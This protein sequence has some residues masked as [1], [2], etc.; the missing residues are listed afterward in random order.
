MRRR[1]AFRV[2]GSLQVI[3]SGRVVELRSAKQRVLLAALLMKANAP[4]S[5]YELMEHL[6]GDEPSGAARATLQ[7]YVMRLRQS[8]DDLADRKLVRTWPTGYSIHVEDDQLDLLTFQKLRAEARRAPDLETEARLLGEAAALWRGPALDQV[9][10]LRME[11]TDVQRLN[12]QRW[13]VLERRNDAELQLGRHDQLV[14]ELRSLVAEHPLRERFWYQLMLALHRSG[15]QAQALDVFRRASEVLADELGID[16]NAELRALHMEVL[17]GSSAPVAVQAGPSWL[18][19]AVGDFSGRADEVARLTTGLRAGGT[20]TITG[21]GGVGKTSLAVHCAHAV[22]DAFPDGQLYLNLRGGE[23]QP[24]GPAAAL[25]RLLRGLGVSGGAIPSS[26]ED[27]VDL[28]RDLLSDRRILVVLDN[29]VNEAQVRPLLP[30]TTS[31]AALVTSR[32]ALAGLEAAHV[33][34]LDVLPQDDALTLLRTAVG[35]ARCAAEP[36]AA[37][38]IVAYCGQLPLAL[39]VAAARLVARPH[40]QLAKLAGRL[41]DERRRFD[42]LSLGDLDVRASLALSYDGLDASHQTAFRLLSLV[43]TPDFPAWTAS[44]LLGLDVDDAEDHVEALVDARLVDYAGRDAAGQVR[45]RLHDLLRAFG[46]EAATEDPAEALKALFEQW[47][48]LA[49]RADAELPHQAIRLEPAELAPFDLGDAATWFD[50]EWQNI[51]ALV[52]QAAALGLGAQAAEL[53]I[54]SAAFCDLRAR[55]DD[56][57]QLNC[58]GLSCAPPE[59]K[60]VLFQQRGILRARMHDYV[61]A[62]ENF[63]AAQEGFAATGDV[64]GE[65]YGWYGMGWMHEWS[66]RSAEA[67][68]A[69]R[70][71]MTRFVASG[72]PHGEIEVLCSLGAIERRAGG[73]AAAT[74][75]LERARRLANS[76]GDEQSEL[77][78]TLELGRLHQFTGELARSA[79][80]LRSSL[81]AARR[82][83]DP[84]MAANIRLF[85][86]DTLIRSDEVALAEEQLR[87]A[88]EFFEEHDDR[89]GRIWVWRLRSGLASSPQEALRL[90]SLALEQA[91]EMDSPPEFGRSLR[92]LGNALERAGR[93]EEAREHWRQ[94]EETLT[95]AGFQAEVDELRLTTRS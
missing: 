79:E 10:S 16:P 17:A 32:A 34:P 61:A 87:L 57:E 50:A 31:G 2:L 9:S 12:E 89:Q 29:A 62:S 3:D 63:Q 41:S 22:R 66:G 28:Y 8:L 5:S 80:F 35:E 95:A 74:G 33:V 44:P 64:W 92:V 15:Q 46:R 49:T 25:D 68:E 48:D 42:E 37:Q 23:Q 82:M 26:V 27:R 39:R 18:P 93:A 36:R 21:P 56:W 30:G 45:Y 43:D 70:Q 19:P 78:A 72:N 58:I 4:V 76:L 1:W 75:Y 52:T 53:A 69:H 24:V 14:D 90:A 83:G 38:E 11:Q 71:A 91:R 88:W 65:A 47:L 40:W 81:A 13:E 59:R 6:W 7:T 54:R 55:F 94:A 20:W 67:R 60:P 73:L 85:L 86:A 84:D 51:H 77:M